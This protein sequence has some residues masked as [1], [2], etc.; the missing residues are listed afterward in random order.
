MREACPPEGAVAGI[1]GRAPGHV[2]QHARARRSRT[3]R[4]APRCGHT[5]MRTWFWRGRAPRPGIVSTWWAK[6]RAMVV[7][8]GAAARVSRGSVHRQPPGL[9]LTGNTAGICAKT[10]RTRAPRRPH[11]TLACHARM[12]HTHAPPAA[13][14]QPE[15]TQ[16]GRAAIAG[17]PARQAFTARP[18]RRTG[19]NDRARPRPRDCACARACCRRLHS[20]LH[21]VARARSWRRRARAA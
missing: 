10:A 11:A 18:M 6:K 15:R 9:R 19:S 8:H 4:P 2:V 3:V 21:A 1:A 13:S 16:T 17:P 5:V 7:W 20:V 12:S 14:A